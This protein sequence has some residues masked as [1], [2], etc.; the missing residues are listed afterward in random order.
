MSRRWRWCLAVVFAAA[1]LG[2]FLPSALLSGPE[3]LRTSTAALTAEA[4]ID[5]LGGCFIPSCGK[6]APA[7]AAPTLTLASLSAL[8]AAGVLAYAASRYSRRIRP[9]LYALPRGSAVVLL[10]PPQFS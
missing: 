1:V 4:P 10:R 7:P 6:S 9:L 8:A 2:S 5:L 3:T